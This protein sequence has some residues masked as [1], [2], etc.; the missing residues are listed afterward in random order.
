M[1]VEHRK[2]PV[3]LGLAVYTLEVIVIFFSSNCLHITSTTSFEASMGGLLAEDMELRLM[4]DGEAALWSR[5]AWADDGPAP[6]DHSL[7]SCWLLLAS[8][9]L[10]LQMNRD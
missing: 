4:P 3:L 10:W 9:S 2:G 1:V 8:F 6:E 7:D 5:I